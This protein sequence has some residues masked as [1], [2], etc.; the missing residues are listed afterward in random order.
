MT[1][2]EF[3]DQVLQLAKL[4]CWLRAH[5]RPALT[6]NGWRTAVQGDGNGFPDLVLL[7]SRT[8][9]VAELKVGKNKP[10]DEQEAWLAAFRLTGARVYV[11]RP[12]DFKEIE[13][14]LEE[15]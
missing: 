13:R 10:T 2:A 6:V 3:T 9:L 8:L 5:F 7:R 4:R 12:E 1:E 14:V 15:A 11:W